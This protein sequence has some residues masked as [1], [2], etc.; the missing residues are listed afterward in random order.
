MNNK[1]DKKQVLELIN[2]SLKALDDNFANQ[3][4]RRMFTYDEIYT[5]FAELNKL[6]AIYY[7]LALFDCCKL[8]INKYIPLLNLIVK[9]DTH[10]DRKVKY[11]ELLKTAYRIGARIS[12]EHFMIYYDW[13]NKDKFY[14]E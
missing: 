6:F 11:S 12:L 3:K 14:E 1:Y 9:L 5:I 4:Y 7:N 8:V 13:D 2:K 10:I